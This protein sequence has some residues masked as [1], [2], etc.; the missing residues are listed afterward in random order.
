MIAGPGALPKVVLC[1]ACDD[2][3]FAPITQG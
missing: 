3:V 2:V 1:R